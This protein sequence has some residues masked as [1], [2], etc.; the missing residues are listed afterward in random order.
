MNNVLKL[1]AISIVSGS[2]AAVMACKITKSPW[3]LMGL[4]LIP[5]FN[6]TQNSQ[7]GGQING[8]IQVQLTQ[9]KERKN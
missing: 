2:V 1:N 7:K 3:C 8:R 4:L 6:F 5:T 9:I